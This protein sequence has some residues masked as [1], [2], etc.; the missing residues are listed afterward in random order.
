MPFYFEKSKRIILARI[1]IRFLLGASLVLIFISE[2][3]LNFNFYF[4]L[5]LFVFSI[6]LDHMIWKYE[7]KV[8]I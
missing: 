6:I 7:K 2:G 1:A 8:M 4:A 5:A 3:R